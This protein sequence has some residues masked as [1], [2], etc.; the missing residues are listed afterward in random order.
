[1]RRV[2]GKGASIL[3]KKCWSKSLRASENSLHRTL[4]AETSTVPAPPDVTDVS[5]AF[6]DDDSSTESGESR[7]Q[8]KS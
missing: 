6:R 1:M 3:Q 7:S 5:S 2:H 8:T 4:S